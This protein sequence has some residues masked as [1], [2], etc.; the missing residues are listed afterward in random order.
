VGVIVCVWLLNEDRRTGRRLEKSS[1][2]NS[3]KI[4]KESSIRADSDDEELLIGDRD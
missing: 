3:K 4:L 2:V 1:S